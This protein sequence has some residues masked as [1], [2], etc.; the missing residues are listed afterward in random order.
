MQPLFSPGIM[1]NSIKS[2]M[3]VDY[4][5]M[6]GRIN[7]DGDQGGPLRISYGAT[8]D[9]DNVIPVLGSWVNA[10]PLQNNLSEPFDN[11]LPFD[12]LLEPLKHL[13]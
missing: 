3:A 12:T 5:L 4:P 8:Y 10:F 13:G 9:P 6:T 2:G 1:F 11:R 7:S